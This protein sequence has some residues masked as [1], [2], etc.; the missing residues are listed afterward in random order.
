LTLPFL[1]NLVDDRS[2]N[3]EQDQDDD[4]DQTAQVVT[5]SG[6]QQTCRAHPDHQT[7]PHAVWS[8]SFSLR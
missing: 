3:R 8:S 5:V 6:G 1:A 2:D 4:A 7:A